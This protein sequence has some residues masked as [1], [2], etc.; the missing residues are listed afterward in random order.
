V[1]AGSNP[2]SPRLDALAFAAVAAVVLASVWLRWP[3]FVEGGF[4]SHDVAGILYNAM[5]LDHG[6]LPY[7][8]TIEIK[9][10]GTFYLAELLAGPQARDIARFQIW[11]N[12]WAVGGLATVAAIAWRT[13][14]R[15]AAVS[16][17]VLYG[18]HDANLDSM[19]ANYV[20]W[21]NLPQIV[22]VGAGLEALR[23]TGRGATAGWLVAGACCG[24]AAL[25]KRPDGI[26]FLVVLAMAAWP[27]EDRRVR[28]QEAGLVSLGAVLS[29]LPIAL[30]Y[31]SHGELGALVDGYLL[32]RWGLRYV[33][34]KSQD[35]FFVEAALASVFFVGLLLV[36]SA[37]S[38]GRAV[39]GDGWRGPT[40]WLT[41]WAVA[42]LVAAF[43]GGR[44]YKGYF[45]ATTAP[46]ALLAAAPFGLFG[47]RPIRP[48]W[49]RPLAL[50]LI[51]PLAV[52]CAFGLRHM[53]ADRARAHDRG[54]RTIADHVV[55]NT[56]TD[57]RIWVWGW[58]LW[59]VYPLADR[60]SGSRIYKSLGL[61]TPP[62]DDSWRRGASPLRFVDG[63]YARML[64]ED[65][66]RSRP[67][68]VVL[69]STVPHR[70]FTALR[71]L[72]RRDYRRDRRVRLGRVQ[73]WRLKDEL[74]PASGQDAPP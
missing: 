24:L 46:L 20:T 31:V 55:A 39:A 63:E 22:A 56:Q 44:F 65:L 33:A 68:Y 11:A 15:A 66:E 42:T 13:W 69:G 43:V 12:L 71:E 38:I 70:D 9:A 19:D 1:A 41:V 10:P 14:G 72:L 57:D 40:R 54:G 49:L 26:V 59:D 4:A 29:Q 28:W 34:E 64:I 52:R 60:M 35:S 37:F 74:A 48:R 50:V 25:F 3:G 73:F 7:V 32:N 30:H 2:P 61:L 8:D 6:G 58:H 51:T 67:R 36:A 53:R 5:V 62:N 27:R 18:L 17:A 45:L 23:R 16:S 47:A 21:A